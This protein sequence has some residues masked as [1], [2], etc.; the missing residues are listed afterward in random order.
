VGLKLRF[1]NFKTITRDCTIEEPT[2]DA[3]L[4]RRAAGSCLKRVTLER[5][6]RLLGVRMGSLSKSGVQT[7][8]PATELDEAASLFDAEQSI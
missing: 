5:R 6:I 4:I 8:A 7:A 1:D 2:R 3:A